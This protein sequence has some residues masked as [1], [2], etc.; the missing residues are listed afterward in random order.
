[1][2]SFA[3]KLLYHIYHSPVSR[4]LDSVRAG[5]PLE[6]RRTERGRLAMEAAARELPLLPEIA[7]SS[8][9]PL[10][11]LT[12]SRFWA[13]TA[14]CLWSFARH[15]RR[16]IA[17]IL[18][19]DGTLTP[20]FREPIARR[21][22]LARFIPQSETLERLDE[23]LPDSRF[24]TIRERWLH[25]PNIRKLTD[26]HAGS[27]EWKLVIDSDLLFFRRPDQLTEWIDAPRHPLHAIDVENSYGY[28]RLLM[29]SLAEN[30]TADRVNVGLCGLHGGQLDWDRLEYWCH[31]LI[32]AEGTNYFLEQALVAMLL[33]GRRCSVASATDYLTLPRPPEV[34]ECK[35]IMHH[36]VANSKRWYF[37]ENWRKVLE[38]AP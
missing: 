24:P 14:F 34:H 29:N 19:D 1:M 10:H 2:R 6:Q 38:P 17:P 7:D 16:R 36:Y 21:F 11:L 32:K 12:G 33:A 35:A 31:S 4:I 23:Y 37:Q 18:Y 5:G 30:Q 25:Y 3:G 28:S 9:V 20:E 13:Q 26:I 8:P 27:A 22:P 15:S